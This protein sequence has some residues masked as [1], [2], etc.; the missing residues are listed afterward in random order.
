MTFACW[1]SIS[2]CFNLVIS[3]QTLGARHVAVAV[4]PSGNRPGEDQAKAGFGS[5]GEEPDR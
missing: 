5:H 1:Q 2:Q 3:I 4:Q